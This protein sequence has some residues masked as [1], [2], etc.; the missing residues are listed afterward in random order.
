ML[1]AVLALIGLVA[2]V[3]SFL[4]PPTAPVGPSI[5]LVL[6]LPDDHPELT[7]FAVSPDGESFAIGTDKG[8]VVRDPGQRE[9]RLLPGTASG[10]SPSF[11]PDGNWL[12]FEQN[13]RLRKI[14]VHGGSATA[15]VAGD[16]IEGNN[17]HW[18]QDGTIAFEARGTLYV[19]TP[20]G[21]PVRR[22]DKATNGAA[23]RLLPSGRGLLYHDPSS[24]SRLMYYDL[25]T[26][27]ISVAVD[28]AG[29]GVFVDGYVLYGQPEGGLFAVPFDPDRGQTT[30]PAVPVASD[31]QVVGSGAAFA[32]S[33]NGLL[34]YR[35]GLVGQSRLVVV[36]A[37]RHQ[38]TLPIAP[39]VVG[40]VKVSPDGR[41]L[42]ITVGAARGSNRHIALF[43]LST[44][45]LSQFTKS[46]GGHAP[47]WSP[48]GRSL[49]FTAEDAGS[50]AED[51]F[52]QPVDGDAAPRRVAR[53]PRDQ[54]A[55]DWP[56]DTTLVFSEGN[57]PFAM[58]DNADVQLVNPMVANA[59][60]RPYLNATWSESGGVVSPDGRWMAYASDE[61]GV[62]EVYVRPFPVPLAGAQWKVSSGGGAVPRWSP[63]GRG[64]FYLGLA[65]GT[66]HRADVRLTPSF[67]IVSNRTIAT[68]PGL[69][70][71]WDVNNRTGQLIVSQEVVQASVR[72]VAIPN[73]QRRLHAV[74]SAK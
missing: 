62:V 16:S 36:G 57:S 44:G 10:E 45:S 47:V 70:G 55:T 72:L 33:R 19:A 38:D 24:G 21:R 13:G 6:E 26:D 3:W 29:A 30:G 71:A 23:P 46:G 67:A 15:L 9:F 73:W 50:D 18:G 69:R 41:R 17:V 34:V 56:N 54:H 22:L 14:S 4:R 43:D 5:P 35:S 7:R 27:R 53:R 63:D 52:V 68:L 37:D 74:G 2:V 64:V 48:D 39:Q 8:V 31:L 61:S 28:Q 60:A 66:I 65:D 51:L 59:T 25:A 32:V 58:R 42:A 49:A 12:A 11:S 40:Y 20:D 1:G